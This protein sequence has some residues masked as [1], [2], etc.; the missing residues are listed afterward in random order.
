MT[1]TN[2]GP[3]TG[4]DTGSSTRLPTLATW[5]AAVSLFALLVFLGVVAIQKGGVD[6]SGIA[7]ALVTALLGAVLN[8]PADKSSPVLSGHGQGAWIA[9]VVVAGA[10]SVLSGVMTLFSSS[11]PGAAG[12]FAASIGG[13]A[14]LLVNTSGFTVVE[15]LLG[16]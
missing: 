15:K 13:L 10:V 8:P 9:L 6:L 12:A 7:P 1:T 3:G 2:S 11:H 5:I 14:G 16:R 4:S